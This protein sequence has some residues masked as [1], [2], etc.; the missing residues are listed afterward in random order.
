MKPLF[1]DQH[2]HEQPFAGVRLTEIEICPPPWQ[3]IPDAGFKKLR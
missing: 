3:A 1:Y 2:I